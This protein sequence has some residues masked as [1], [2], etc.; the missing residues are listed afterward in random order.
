MAMQKLGALVVAAFVCVTP[1]GCKRQTAKHENQSVISSRHDGKVWL[2]WSDHERVHFIAA[3]IDGYEMG[4]HN[5]C[6]AV[7]QL[8]DLKTNHTYA[9]SKDE[10]VLP[11]GVC[12]IAAAHYSR[13]K[14]NSDGDPDVSAYTDVFTR[15]Y[16]EHPEYQNIPYE[17]LVQYLTDEQKK[18]ADDL[19]KM[20]NAGEMRT[21]W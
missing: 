7:D 15:F 1:L 3:Y 2:D 12:R 18:T 17:Y 13:F 9:H 19:F 14:P 11:S 8:L 5:A 16:T 6:S 4:V 21:H 20:A 10:I